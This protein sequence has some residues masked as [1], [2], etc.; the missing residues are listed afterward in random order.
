MRRGDLTVEE[1]TGLS[2]ERIGEVERAYEALPE[3]ARGRL[4]PLYEALGGRYGYA[5]LRCVLAALD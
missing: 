2:R 1:A 4:K 5:Q 3:D